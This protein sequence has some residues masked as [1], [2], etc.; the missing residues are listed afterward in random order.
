M[1]MLKKIVSV[2]FSPLTLGLLAALVGFVLIW[3]PRRRR[4]GAWCLILGLLLIAILGLSWIADP[5][6]LPL[7]WKYEPYREGI[8]VEYVVVLGSGHVSDASLPLTSQIHETA[9]VRLVEGIRIHRR[10]PGSKLV[11]SGGMVFDPIPHA[12]MMANL[13]LELGVNEEDVILEIR[14]LDTK[15]EALM[16]S[17]IVGAR[18]FVLVTSAVHMPRAVALFRH[19]GAHPIPAPTGHRAKHRHVAPPSSFVPRAGNL[20][21]VEEGM[22]E[23]LGI[24]WA[25][26]RGQI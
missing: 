5:F 9:I 23:Y 19:Q 13:A 12:V 15:D 20:R 11:L 6:L 4:A 8:P 22:H 14:P 17:E 16:I 3:F 24:A 2:F 18:P 7:E 10:H 26:L 21:K 1:F 25:W